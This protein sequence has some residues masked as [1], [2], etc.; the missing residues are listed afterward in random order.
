MIYLIFHLISN[1]FLVE[2]GEN[3]IQEKVVQQEEKM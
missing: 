2:R 3:A 1:S